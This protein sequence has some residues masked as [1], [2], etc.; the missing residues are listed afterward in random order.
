MGE[1]SFPLKWELNYHTIGVNES[2]KKAFIYFGLLLKVESGGDHMTETSKTGMTP[3]NDKPT[4]SSNLGMD[5]DEQRMNGMYGMAETK[6][7][8]QHQSKTKETY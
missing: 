4:T 1:N 5:Q 8:D 3:E 6:E 7:E 2:P